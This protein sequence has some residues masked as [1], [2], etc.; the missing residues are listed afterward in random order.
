MVFLVAAAVCIMACALFPFLMPCF[1]KK[2]AME[3]GFI[4]WQV[5]LFIAFS[6]VIYVCGAIYYMRLAQKSMD[7]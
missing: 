5:I 6:G 3:Y 4:Y 2:A 1:I 7:T